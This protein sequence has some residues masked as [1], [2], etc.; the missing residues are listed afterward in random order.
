MTRGWHALDFNDFRAEGSVK[1][2]ITPDELVDGIVADLKK[3]GFPLVRRNLII[4]CGFDGP[5]CVHKDDVW[6]DFVLDSLVVKFSAR[7]FE[8]M[9]LQ[10]RGL[11]RRTAPGGQRY[12]KMHGFLNCLVLTSDDRKYLLNQMQPKLQEA[13]VQAEFEAQRFNE[14]FVNNPHPNLYVEPRHV[15]RRRGIA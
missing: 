12:F 15:P 8:E 3:R 10:L 2:H 1:L 6:Y 4:E 5:G 7:S 11:E 13:L 14:T 9:L